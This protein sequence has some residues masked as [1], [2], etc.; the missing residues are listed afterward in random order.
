MATIQ[1]RIDET[2]KK[3]AETLFNNMGLDTATA[4]RLFLKQSVN[5]SALPFEVRYDP[6]YS[7]QNQ[8]EL[9]RRIAQARSGKTKFVTKTLE[10]LQAL[11]NG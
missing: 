4:I 9:K 10:E 11:E 6:F 5:Q 1:L 3:D 8:R 7:E 2:L